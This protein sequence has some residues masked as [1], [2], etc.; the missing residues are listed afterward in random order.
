MLLITLL[1]LACGERAAP[2]P[3][4]DT[5]TFCPALR[6]HGLDTAALA[7]VDRQQ[8]T[9]QPGR[10]VLL[11]PDGFLAHDRSFLPL[12]RYEMPERFVEL[13]LRAP[14]DEPTQRP[15]PELLPVPM[16]LAPLQQQLEQA[17]DGWADSIGGGSADYSGQALLAVEQEVTGARLVA[18]LQLF[19]ATQ[20]PELSFVAASS[21]GTVP[22][23]LSPAVAQAQLAGGERSWPATCHEA[24]ELIE[25]AIEAGSV[26]GAMLTRM[27]SEL[28][29]SLRSCS[30]GDIAHVMTN[31]QLAACER[32]P[33]ALWNVTIDPEGR[34]VEVAPEST[35]DD[36]AASFLGFEGQ[37]IWP[38]LADP[39]GARGD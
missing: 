4:L 3:A 19:W 9:T 18:T 30:A 24:S 23:W 28:E 27:R 29:R 1:L 22:L 37:S 36:L 38:V 39:E 7:S 21:S 2:I 32:A 8:S 5:T 10:M 14:D 26:G 6:S 17:L 35:W 16:D 31:Y 25:H 33:V 15:A 12:G 34:V 13:I 20:H 11:R